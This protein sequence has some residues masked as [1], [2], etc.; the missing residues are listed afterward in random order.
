[1]IYRMCRRDSLLTWLINWQPGL[2]ACNCIKCF[3]LILWLQALKGL[4]SKPSLLRSNAEVWRS[5]I[6]LGSGFPGSMISCFH[7]RRLSCPWYHD[8]PRTGNLKLTIYYSRYPN[9]IFFTMKKGIFLT[10]VVNYFGKPCTA[11]LRS[12]CSTNWPPSVPYGSAS[13]LDHTVLWWPCTVSV[14]THGG[15]YC[16]E[17]VLLTTLPMPKINRFWWRNKMDLM[18]QSDRY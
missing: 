12:N 3:D 5:K 1:M 10:K 8:T 13:R 4:W 15:L 7:S 11:A 9:I 6:T 2:Q 18:S 16:T 14:Q 17:V